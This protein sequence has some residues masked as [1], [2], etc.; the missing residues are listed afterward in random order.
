MLDLFADAQRA[1]RAFGGARLAEDLRPTPMETIGAGIVRRM[2]TEPQISE[3]IRYE[4]VQERI[5]EFYRETGR[6]EIRNPFTLSLPGAWEN[7]SRQYNEWAA[8]TD[9]DPFPTEQ[10]M[11]GLV[12]DWQRGVYQEKTETLEAGG[13]LAR[14]IGE[15]GADLGDPIIA[16]SLMFGAA[17]ATGIIKTAVTEAGLGFGAEVVSGLLRLRQ[18]QTLDPDFTFGDVLRES[19]TAGAGGLV[20]GGGIKAIAAVWNLVRGA[21]TW[22]ATVRDAGDMTERAAAR[23]V[24][25]RTPQ[26]EQARAEAAAQATLDLQAEKPITRP[27]AAVADAN[28]RVGRVFD[29]SGR[30]IE[31]EYQVVELADLIVSNLPDFRVNPHFPGHLQPR[32]RTRAPSQDQVTDI[33]TNLEPER[34][35]V[36]AEAAGGAP[37]AGPDLVVE[38]GNARVLA[39]QRAYRLAGEQSAAY[40]AFLQRQGFD[41]SDMAEPVMI[42]R[43]VTDLDDAARLD[44][45]TAANRS[46]TLRMGATET[47]LADARLLD[48][49]LISRLVPGD[50]ESAANRPFVRGFV[51]KLPSGERG[52]MMGAGGTLSQEGIRRI[53]GALLGRAYGDPRLLDR[54][55]ENTDSNIRSI[56]NAM[57]DAAGPWTIMRDAVARGDLPPGMNITEDLLGAVR[58]V[59]RARDARRPIAEFAD[60]GE[61]LGGPSEIS[62]LLLRGMFR[63]NFKSPAARPKIAG[64]LRLYTDEALKNTAGGRL[65]GEPLGA[66]AVLAASLRKAE[67]EDLFAAA[68]EQ[69][70]P[71]KIDELSESA[72]A[73][74]AVVRHAEE[75]SQGDKPVMVARG[76]GDDA[77]GDA[78]Y[79]GRPLDEVFDEVDGEIVTAKDIE[80]CATGK[81]VD[82]D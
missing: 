41:V 8:E 22:N 57:A 59:M 40:R 66:N 27:P 2:V 21:R 28:A 35:G 38:S 81:L 15:V 50:I 80:D 36:S 16:G 68:M 23:A 24:P 61:F 48:E 1:T 79:A 20:L 39:I 18:T 29:A 3:I 4:I 31:V 14:F 82:E 6:D 73:K 34:L 70:T 33:A 13:G 69:T 30:E 74:E 25:G 67:R 7:A 17:W 11:D 53:R 71:E 76:R 26:Q 62:K 65:F 32:D 75:L 9:R 47:A 44:F 56:G 45:V 12:L 37:I 60:Q 63:A 78:V 5:N 43:R 58:V 55:L 72:E 46:Q 52:E 77:D 19:T 10:E 54:V 51:D 64:M 49:T 42:A